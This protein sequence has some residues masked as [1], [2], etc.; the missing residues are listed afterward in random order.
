MSWF[1]DGAFADL[2]PS[3]RG[4]PSVPADVIATVMVLLALEGLS[5]REDTDALRLRDWKVAC[6]LALSDEGLPDNVHVLAQPAAQVGS[7]AVDLRRRRRGDPRNR[8]LKG[9][10][11]RALDSTVVDD[12]V[13]TQDTVRRV[14]KLI[15][16]GAAVA[17]NGHDYD[18]PGKPACAWDD[19]AARDALV[20]ALGQ[21][22]A[23]GVGRR[24]RRAAG[25][26][27]PRRG[28]D[29]RRAAGATC[30]GG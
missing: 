18:Q 21:R 17:L 22:R 27:C 2:F 4:R 1:P 16:A 13:A 9:K 7:A 29:P 24:Q 23:H 15:P 28:D 10:R 6:G 8:V 19:A 5:D 14:R 20:T 12:A 26:H 25:A 11:R 30:P 3:G